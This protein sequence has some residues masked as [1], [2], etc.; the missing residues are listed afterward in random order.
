MLSIIEQRLN[1][2]EINTEN[3]QENA[4]KEI[5]QEIILSALAETN[6]G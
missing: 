2:Y 5:M 1:K 6:L 3:Q 4:L